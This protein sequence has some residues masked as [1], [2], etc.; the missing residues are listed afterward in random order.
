MRGA[1]CGCGGAGAAPASGPGPEA[2]APAGPGAGGTGPEGGGGA[3]RCPGVPGGGGG[4]DSSGR[5][6]HRS[7]S[8]DHLSIGRPTPRPVR[9]FRIP[10]DAVTSRHAGDSVNL[11]AGQA[12][13]SAD[14]VSGHRRVHRRGRDASGRRGQDDTRTHP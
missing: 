10:Q 9:V 13:C 14:R 7:R 8:A 11:A 4:S 5:C 6:S 1:P 3:C 12:T 2:A